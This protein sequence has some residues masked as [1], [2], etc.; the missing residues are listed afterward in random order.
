MCGTAAVDRTAGGF[1]WKFNS[2]F[3]PPPTQF[4]KPNLTTWSWRREGG[5]SAHTYRFL[6]LRWY[7][8][9]RFTE[10]KDVRGPQEMAR[11]GLGGAHTVRNHTSNHTAWELKLKAVMFICLLFANNFLADSNKL[12]FGGCN[13]LHRAPLHRAREWYRRMMEKSVVI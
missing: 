10:V 7:F 13:Y 8:H 4:L 6:T 9:L 5:G 1:N 11:P 12:H 2:P 3:G